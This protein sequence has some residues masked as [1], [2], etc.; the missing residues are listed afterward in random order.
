MTDYN[1]SCNAD[2]KGI[3]KNEVTLGQILSIIAPLLVLLIGAWITN[4][5]NMTRM[6]ERQKM[7]IERA[8]EDRGHSEKN[9]VLILT[10][11]KELGKQINSIEV[12][13]NNKQNKK[14]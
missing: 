10:E 7:I 2:S 12:E 13:I 11:I 1:S 4:Q 5:I 8:L 6:E 9:Q 14:P 3:F